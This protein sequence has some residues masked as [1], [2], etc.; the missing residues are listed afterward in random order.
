[1]L[2]RYIVTERLN[3]ECTWVV[4]DFDN[5]TLL[6]FLT[7]SVRMQGGSFFIPK[8]GIMNLYIIVDKNKCSIY[9]YNHGIIQ[10]NL[11][12]ILKR[13][14]R[15]SNDWQAFSYILT[16]SIPKRLRIWIAETLLKFIIHYL[17]VISSVSAI[18]PINTNSNYWQ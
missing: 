15:T 3:I 5:W 17:W 7:T 2:Q 4:Q 12:N 10:E 16:N 8:N 11:S 13:C 1:M 14:W 18:N 9:N 6:W